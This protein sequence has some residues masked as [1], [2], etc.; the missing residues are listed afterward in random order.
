[1]RGELSEATIVI[2][3]EAMEVGGRG[4]LTGDDLVDL[5]DLEGPDFRLGLDKM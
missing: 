3:V 2:S 1:M 5:V 4:S